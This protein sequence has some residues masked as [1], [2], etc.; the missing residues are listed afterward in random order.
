MDINNNGDVALT[1]TLPFIEFTFH[2]LTFITVL[3]QNIRNEM[4]R[5]Y[6]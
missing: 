2:N 5:K 1:S 4:R 6:K 3:H